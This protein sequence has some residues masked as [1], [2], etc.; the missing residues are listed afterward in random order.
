LGQRVASSEIHTYST[1]DDIYEKAEAESED[2]N[3]E[4]VDFAVELSYKIYVNKSI[5]RKKD[6]SDTIRNRLLDLYELEEVISK[7]VNLLRKI[8]HYFTLNI[9]WWTVFVD[10]AGKKSIYK[11]YDLDDFSLQQG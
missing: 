8:E 2:I 6:L 4:I 7:E 3:K 9:I 1:S 11:A 5:R 10:I